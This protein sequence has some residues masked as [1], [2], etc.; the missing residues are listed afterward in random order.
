MKED[1]VKLQKYQLPA[2]TKRNA[3]RGYQ[4]YNCPVSHLFYPSITDYQYFF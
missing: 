4:L 3:S 2:F 1:K